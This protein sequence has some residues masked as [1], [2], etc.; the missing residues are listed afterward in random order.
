M[1]RQFGLKL[2]SQDPCNL[3][4]VM[5]RVEPQSE[6]VVSLKT[7]PSQHTSPECANHG[8]R[9][10]RPA[11]KSAVPSLQPG[12]SH[13]LREETKGENL[14]VFVDGSVVWEGVLGSDALHLDRPVG[15]RSDNAHVEF[16]LGVVDVPGV[17]PNVALPCK[18]G[19]SESE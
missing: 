15:I 6:L 10:I 17:H 9:N 11:H 3:V 16:Q 19:P 1:R 18:S 13:T 5:W 14:R 7:N 8:Y 12:D 4:Y 2:R